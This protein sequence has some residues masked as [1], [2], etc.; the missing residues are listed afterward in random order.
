GL[1]DRLEHLAHGDL[2]V[3]HLDAGLDALALGDG[4]GG[5][6]LLLRQD[7]RQRAQ[8][9]EVGVVAQLALGLL[10]PRPPDAQ[11]LF[12]LNQ[13]LDLPFTVA[14]DL[15][16]PLLHRPGG[17]QAALQVGVLLGD[18]LAADALAL[19]L[20]GLAEFPAQAEHQAVELVGRHADDDGA[21]DLAVGQFLAVDGGDEAALGGGDQLGDGGHGG[22]ERIDFKFDLAGADDLAGDGLRGLLRRGGRVFAARLLAPVAGGRLLDPAGSLTVLVGLTFALLVPFVFSVFFRRLAIGL[23][24]G[25]F[26]AEQGVG[27]A[28]LEVAIFGGT[29]SRRVPDGNTIGS[30]IL[31]FLHPAVVSRGDAA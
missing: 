22:V 7:D 5:A 4:G 15:Q 17:A 24:P 21:A 8:G 18:V 6:D 10:D 1:G 3:L 20:A 14:D 2:D 23:F 27:V 29:A 30:T 28:R 11:L 25:T 12:R 19:Q 26:R 16:Q 31:Q 13:V 9:D